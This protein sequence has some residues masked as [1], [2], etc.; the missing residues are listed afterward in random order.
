[1][2]AQW[3]GRVVGKMHVRGITAKELAAHLGYNEKYVSMVLNGKRSPK[4]AE[5]RFTHAL[6]ELITLREQQKKE[7]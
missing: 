1:M 7:G 2:P 3:T 5:A 4:D 6:D